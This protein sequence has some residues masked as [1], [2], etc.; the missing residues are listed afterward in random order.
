MHWH[1]GCAGIAVATALSI[2][3][4][5]L[6]GQAAQPDLT[7]TAVLAVMERAADW[8]IGHPSAHKPTDWT[9]A[10][11]DAGIMALAGIS[12]SP[13]FRDSMLAAGEANQWQ[14]GPRVYHADD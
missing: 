8:Q 4:P 2:A 13:R 12:G 3:V 5:M 10:A 7:P 9:Q 1:K 14:L 6:R 11:G